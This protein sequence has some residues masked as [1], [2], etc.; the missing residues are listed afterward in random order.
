MTDQ[1]LD[2]L[3]KRIL[4]DS[5]RLEYEAMERDCTFVFQPS[6]RHQRQMKLMLKDPLEWARKRTRPVW[7]TIAQRVAV[8]LLIIS[9][10]FGT[11]MVSSPT[12]RAAFVRWI[13]EW[14][15]THVVYRYA[16]SE[17]AES[18]PHYEITEL[19]EGFVEA[20]RSELPRVTSVT[21]ENAAGDVIYFEYGFMAQ[22]GVL[23]VDTENLDTYDIKV[24]HMDGQLFESKTPG[25]FNMIT[26]FDT[27]QNIQ[28]SI[29]GMFTYM[30]ILHMAENV[31]LIEMTK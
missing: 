8:V 16:G 18:L 6:A 2:A 21:Y 10:G 4:I 22:G 17:T 28:F 30:D 26:W 9:L 12:A 5:I 29:N 20:E 23:A 15:E 11:V 1:E 14:Y 24:N 7:K 13:T 27:E 25:E 31:S 19:P 3:M